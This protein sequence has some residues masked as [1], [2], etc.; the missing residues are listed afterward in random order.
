[1]AHGHRRAVTLIAGSALLTAASGGAVA[2]LAGSAAAATAPGISGSCEPLRS[3]SAPHTNAPATAAPP[4]T[5]TTP[6]P[7][8]TPTDTTPTPTPTPAGTTPTSTPSPTDTAPAPAPTPTDTAPTPTPAPATPTPTDTPTTSATAAGASGQAIVLAAF[9]AA[10]ASTTPASLCVGVLPLQQ[11]SVRGQAAQWEVGA[12]AQG[13]NLPDAKIRLQATAGAGTPSFSFGCENGNGTSACDLGA[14]DASS[15]QR[16]FQ[17]EVTVPLTA[18]TVTAVSLTVTGSAAG[19]AT[20]PA[21]AATIIVQ[22]PASPVAAT[23]LSAMPP[24]G[25]AAP[26]P[27][28]SPGGNAAGLFPAV[29][30]SPQAEGEAPVASVS[31][32]SGAAENSEIAEGAGLAALAAAMLLTVTRVSLRRPAPRHAA[33]SAAATPPPPAE[34]HE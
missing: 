14:V 8:P 25:I 15:A 33:S 27:T 24:P 4:A 1:M 5:A 18:A 9:R 7:T 30:P 26:T 21:A 12:W 2:A 17:A 16:L 32:L 31:A 3:V 29:S 10:A 22:A 6:A 19:L 20:D 28:L 11:S 13:G 34:H 23:S